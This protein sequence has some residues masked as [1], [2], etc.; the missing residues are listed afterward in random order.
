MFCMVIADQA[1]RAPCSG[2]ALGHPGSSCRAAGGTPHAGRW[3]PPRRCAWSAPLQPHLPCLPAHLSRHMRDSL[4]TQSSIIR[5][6]THFMLLQAGSDRIAPSAPTCPVQESC[7]NS[8]ITK[9]RQ[10]AEVCMPLPAMHRKGDL[11]SA[12][13]PPAITSL[14]PARYLVAEWMTMSAP[15]VMARWLMGVAKVES[16]H[17]SVPAL[18]HS[19][20]IVGM[21]TQRRYGLVGDSE[22]NRLTFCAFSARSNPCAAGA[23]W[24]SRQRPP[25]APG[26]CGNEMRKDLHTGS[27][28]N[29]NECRD[30]KCRA[31]RLFLSPPECRICNFQEGFTRLISPPIRNKISYF[32]YGPVN[33]HAALTQTCVAT[34][35]R[36]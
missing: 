30:A 33:G 13:S 16:M 10:R 27:R 25:L 8:V 1:G 2:A 11:G 28:G 34:K 14:W 9:R 26:H 3:S 5:I 24:L 4:R 19:R 18:W 35:S 20:E 15:S 36:T 17:T 7:R 23:S 31:H 12:V 21:S 6:S 29:C 22:K 32:S